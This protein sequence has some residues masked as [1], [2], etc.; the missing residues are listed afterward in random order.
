MLLLCMEEIEELLEATEEMEMEMEM[1]KD[2]HTVVMKNIEI[3]QLL[4]ATRHW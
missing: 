4:E 1:E 2:K 3:D